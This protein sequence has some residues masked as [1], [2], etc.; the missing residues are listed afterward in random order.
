MSFNAKL[1]YTSK[2]EIPVT[3]LGPENPI[4]HY[5]EVLLFEDELGDKGYSKANVR[6]RVMDDC[7]FVLMRSYFRIDN[8]LARI[9]DTRIYHEFGSNYIIRDF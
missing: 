4:R 1:D 3:K 7:F 9:L 8:V 6:F 2:I 5:G